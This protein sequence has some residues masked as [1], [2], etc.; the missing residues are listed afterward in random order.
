MELAREEADLKLAGEW[1]KVD[2][3][4]AELRHESREMKTALKE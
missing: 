1:E 4:R 3:E 2:E